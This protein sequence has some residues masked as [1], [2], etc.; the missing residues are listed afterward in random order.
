M[1]GTPVLHRRASLVAV[2]DDGLARLVGV[3]FASLHAGRGFGLAADPVGIDRQIFVIDCPDATGK[4]TVAHIINPVLELPDRPCDLDE[5]DERCL[6]FPG[7]LARIQRYKTASF[8]GVDL[9]GDSVRIDGTGLLAR[10]LQ[11]EYD[12]LQG[13]VYIDRLTAQ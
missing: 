12:H 13:T 3:R 4:R 8:T 9:N 7:R 10:Y 6:S 11:H 5:S 1:Y 2:F